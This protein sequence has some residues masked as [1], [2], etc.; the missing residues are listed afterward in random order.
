MAKIRIPNKKGPPA[1]FDDDYGYALSMRDLDALDGATI[2]DIG[3][4]DS[5]NAIK[6]AAAEFGLGHAPSRPYASS[7]FDSSR[8]QV[9]RGIAKRLAKMIGTGKATRR[10]ALEPAA[11]LIEQRTVET[12]ES[13]TEP[14]SAPSTIEQKGLDDP[15]EETGALKGSI[16]TRITEGQ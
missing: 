16:T 9:E 1:V 10:D 15:L 7:A 14:G 6:A 3:T 12:L 11:E 4:F 2:A 13:W 5:T 8:R